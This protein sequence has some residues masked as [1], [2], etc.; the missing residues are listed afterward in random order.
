MERRPRLRLDASVKASGRNRL[1]RN[2]CLSTPSRL[3]APNTSG[4][5]DLQEFFAEIHAGGKVAGARSQLAFAGRTGSG[6]PIPGRG[7]HT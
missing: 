2:D 7:F 6:D 5:V 4:S 1:F 3:P